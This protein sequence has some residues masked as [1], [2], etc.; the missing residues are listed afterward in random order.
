MP[1]LNPTITSKSP[2]KVREARVLRD[3]G[4][5][6]FN[7]MTIQ[8]KVTRDHRREKTTDRLLQDQKQL[9]SFERHVVRGRWDPQT[10]PG[11]VKQNQEASK[12]SMRSVNQRV[13]APAGCN[14]KKAGRKQD[15]CYRRLKQD[16]RRKWGSERNQAQHHCPALRSGRSC[17]LGS[18]SMFHLDGP[19][20]S[21]GTT[22]KESQLHEISPSFLPTPVR[23]QNWGPESWHYKHVHVESIS[24][25]LK[26]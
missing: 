24:S 19:G 25:I 21:R 15:I 18:D 2:G 11:K 23:S 8:C 22:L 1:L 17:S 4:A 7:R 13:V 6:S 20:F 5:A 9:E 3:E 14:G 26:S 10:E 16:Y 12:D